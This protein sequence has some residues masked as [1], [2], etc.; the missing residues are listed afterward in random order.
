[1]TPFDPE[2]AW[3]PY[4]SLLPTAQMAAAI[5]NAAKFAGEPLIDI[6]PSIK[7]LPDGPKLDSLFLTTLHLWCEVSVDGTTFDFIDREH[8]FNLR[9]TLGTAEVRAQDGTLLVNYETASLV[10]KHVATFSSTLN[11]VGHRRSAWIASVLQ[12]FPAGVVAA[13][14]H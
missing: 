8:I 4:V 9:W 1:M 3:K 12:A 13:R 6:I 14:R 2:K 5:Q 7:L 11:Y 10:V